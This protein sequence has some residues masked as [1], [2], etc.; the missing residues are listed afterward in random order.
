MAGNLDTAAPEGGAGLQHHVFHVRAAGIIDVHCGHRK[1]SRALL[2][3]VERRSPVPPLPAG[4]ADELHIGQQDMALARGGFLGG[5]GF[6][7]VGG[8]DKLGVLQADLQVAHDHLGQ[9]EAKW[10]VRHSSGLAV[11]KVATARQLSQVEI[12]VRRAP[13]YQ[14]LPVSLSFS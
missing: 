14:S 12:V 6:C 9:A 13:R 7:P 5:G 8:F 4:I 11:A 1:P 2:N 10:R 3:L